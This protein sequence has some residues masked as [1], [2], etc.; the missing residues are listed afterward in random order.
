MMRTRALPR[1]RFWRS[2]ALGW[3]GGA[4]GAS[5]SSRGASPLTGGAL[6][7]L[8]E[9]TTI[10]AAA[11]TD[12]TIQIPQNAIVSRVE[13]TVMVAIPTATAFDYGVA[14]A[15][16]RYG[17]AVPVAI[18]TTYPGTNDGNRLYAAAVS[19][20]FTPNVQPASNAGRVLTTIYYYGP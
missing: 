12:T 8:S 4:G 15:T 18:T 7:A 20:R 5:Q 10:A 3:H 9:T 16:A 13:V 2:G 1:Q 6:L 17:A 11:T 14:G 19:I